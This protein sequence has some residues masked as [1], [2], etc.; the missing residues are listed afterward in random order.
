MM[1]SVV[2]SVALIGAFAAAAS[3]DPL[4]RLTVPADR[5]PQGCALA[6]RS[7]TS[8]NGRVRAWRLPFAKNPWIGTDRSFLAS[9]RSLMWSPPLMPDGPPLS[10]VEAQ[11]YSR[12]SADGLEAGY[13]AFY[14][15]KA[16]QES[17]TVYAVRVEDAADID[18]VAPRDHL[19]AQRI[20]IGRTVAMVF[21]GENPGD[22][23][24]AVSRYVR[25]LAR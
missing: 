17:L 3:V 2:A 4:E 12:R 6:P 21:G 18:E 1:R 25:S 10:P 14:Y 8:D 20:R 19:E 23:L 15:S 22:C 24:T 9:I 7:E 13:I 5:L 11:R 16:H